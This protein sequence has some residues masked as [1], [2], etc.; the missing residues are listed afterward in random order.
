MRTRIDSAVKTFFRFVFTVAILAPLLP[1]SS[2]QKQ[3][4]AGSPFA[5]VIF[6][7]DDTSLS[8]FNLAFQRAF[9]LRLLET[10][11]SLTVLAPVNTAMQ[12]AGLSAPVINSL[13]PTTL[14]SFVRYHLITSGVRFTKNVNSSFISSL[15]A[16]VYG[17]ADGTTDYFNGSMA[18]RQVLPVTLPGSNRRS[19]YKL[20]STL[21]VPSI[22]LQSLLASDSSFS[23]LGEAVLRTHL[24]ASLTTI[25]GFATLLAPNNNAFRNAGY[26]DITAIDNANLGQLTNLVQYQVLAGQYFTNN[27]A[28]LTTVPTLS[29]STVKVSVSNG[30]PQFTGNG[31]SS[32]AGIGIGNKLAGGNLVV[33]EIN[34]VLLP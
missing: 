33:Q 11:D 20:R 28:G 24:A 6:I 13:S 14:D 17:T 27:F 1:F 16:G 18:A 3:T 23:L 22:T 2:C 34:Q 9:D 31:N 7:E 25:S 12:S 5:Q 29:G 4:P 21:Q 10:F 8:L 15:G 19:L 32:A 30:S 26:A